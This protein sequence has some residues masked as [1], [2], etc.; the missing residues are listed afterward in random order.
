[1]GNAG[2]QRLHWAA[3]APGLPIPQLPRAPDTLSQDHV[4]AP[5]PRSVGKQSYGADL[6]IF[7]RPG[8]RNNEGHITHLSLGSS[9]PYKRQRKERTMRREKTGYGGFQSWVCGK[10]AA[11]SSLQFTKELKHKGGCHSIVLQSF[12]P[13]SLPPFLSS[14]HPSFFPSAN[15]AGSFLWDRLC[16]RC[17]ECTAL[18]FH[19]LAKRMCLSSS[20]PHT[21]FL[22]FS[23][24][25]PPLLSGPWA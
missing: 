3:C 14:F 4:W 18:S 22:S 15:T 20:C 10:G 2:A 8:S 12:L 19:P 1:M 21:Q 7:P 13:P 5:R 24:N 25:L 23:P 17:W 11:H 6:K 9:K 16:A